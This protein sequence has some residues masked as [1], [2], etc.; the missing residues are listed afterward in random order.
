[1]VVWFI[2]FALSFLLFL[3]WNRFR[4]NAFRAW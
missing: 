1:M 3:V 2:A 4:W